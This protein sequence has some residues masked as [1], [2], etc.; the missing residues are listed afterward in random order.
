MFWSWRIKDF[1]NGSFQGLIYAFSEIKHN[2]SF[3]NLYLKYNKNNELD[4]ALDACIEGAFKSLSQGASQEAFPNEKSFCV[5]STLLYDLVYCLD[6]CGKI[7]NL[8]P[9]E[10]LILEKSSKYISK[11]IENHANI[12][13][14]L[15]SALCALYIFRDKL[16]NQ[17]KE[18]EN[19][20]EAIVKRLNSIWSEEGWFEEYG[21]SDIGYLTLSLQYL[22]RI[23]DIEFKEKEIWCQKIINFLIHF[24]HTDG[25]I[26][27]YYGSRGSSV[28]YPAG[29]IKSGYAEINNDLIESLKKNKIP[30]PQDLDDTNFVPCLNSFVQSYIELNQ[31]CTKNIKLPKNQ[32]KYLKIFKKAGFLIISNQNE[33]TIIDLKNAGSISNFSKDNVTREGSPLIVHKKRKTIYRVLNSEYKIEQNDDVNITIRG[34]FYKTNTGSIGI[35]ETLLSRLFL[36]GISY[37]PNLFNLIKF[38]IAKKYFIP[39]K[40]KGFFEKKR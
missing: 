8:T 24:F 33:Q 18:V 7:D 19:G 6:K 20:I 12:G 32:D 17:N 39:S 31:G 16:G 27:N 38:L 1:N 11:Y 5:T 3:N 35:K 26:G 15:V 23:D 25:S 2:E 22:T 37:F 34:S 30:L 14:H 40:K 13:N 28:I 4:L 36:P 29:L 9:Q 21:A 10:I